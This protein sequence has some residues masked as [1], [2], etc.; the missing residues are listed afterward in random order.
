MLTVTTSPNVPR[1]GQT[2]NLTGSGLLL[3][4]LG[5]IGTLASLKKKTYRRHAAFLRVT[6][7]AL[8]VVTLALTLVSC[9]GYTTSGQTNRGTASIMLTAQAG[10]ISHTTNI[11]ITVQ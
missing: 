3:A 1:Y 9:G 8:T 4:S 6:A 2:L 7:S 11:S 5:L 10:A